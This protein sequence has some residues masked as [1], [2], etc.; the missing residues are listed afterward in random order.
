MSD[1]PP[2][3]P[4]PARV[5]PPGVKPATPRRT[6]IMI[7]AGTAAAAIGYILYRKHQAT[8]AAAAAASS[9]STTTSSQGTQ[10]APLPGSG[11]LQPII[12]GQ[13]GGSTGTGTTT[14]PASTTSTGTTPLSNQGFFGGGYGPL[15]PSDW[16]SG[17]QAAPIQ[18]SDGH[19]YEWLP[20][21]AAVIAA[22]KAGITVFY[23]P[24]E[25]EFTPIPKTGLPGGTPSFIRAD[26]SHT[27]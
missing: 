21:A 2:T 14:P 20:T 23:E 11:V 5:P 19:I 22:Q 26:V 12:I 6:Q 1:I 17:A 18:G 13:G 15:T 7:I 27:A 16:K 4:P 10:A 8:V 9:G 3:L 24:T 25:G